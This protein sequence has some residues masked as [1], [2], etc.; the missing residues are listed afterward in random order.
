M[1]DRSGLKLRNG[2][3]RGISRILYVM[4]SGQML[5]FSNDTS[6]LEAT[7][8]R[9]SIDHRAWRQLYSEDILSQ[10]GQNAIRE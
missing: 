3:N 10:V 2:R 6:V 7:R 5:G 4:S 8:L 9:D 1:M